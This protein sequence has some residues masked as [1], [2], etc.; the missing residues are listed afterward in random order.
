[1]QTTARAII[2]RALR[3][4]KVIA[5]NESGSAAD[6]DTG[7]LALNDMLDSMAIARNN[8]LS[9]VIEQFPLISGQAAYTIGV[10]GDFNTA[11]PTTMEQSSYIRFQNVDFPLAPIDE[12]T[13]SLIPYKTTGG[14]PMTYW[15][16]RNVS[17]ATV[18]FF[19]VPQQQQTLFLHTT[20]QFTAFAGLDTAYVM[21]PGYKE[22][23]Q[24]NLAVNLATEFETE[25]PK[26]VLIKAMNLKRVLKRSNVV[27]P[28]M[29]LHV[30][31]NTG[32]GWNTWQS[33]P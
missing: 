3:L 16:D 27:V 32:P 1:M 15:F 31:A 13:Y 11:I 2:N 22:M 18:T 12:D 20:K 14:I 29:E 24:F 26:T 6:L 19:P 21:G 10:G 33:F 25:A 4:L 9:T 5:A 7:L 8:I 17:L 23:L 28:V 30:P